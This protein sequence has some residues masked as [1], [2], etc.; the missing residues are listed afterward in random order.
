MDI[1]VNSISNYKTTAHMFIDRKQ[2]E[3]PMSRQHISQS[4]QTVIGR[5]TVG[6]IPGHTDNYKGSQSITIY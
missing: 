6:F 1:M 2:I 5:R 3:L 4:D